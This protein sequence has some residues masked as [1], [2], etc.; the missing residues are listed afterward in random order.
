MGLVMNIQRFSLHDGPG[1]RTTAF[2][3]GC[4]LRCRWCHNPESWLMKRRMMFYPNK[5]IGCGRCLSLCARGAH[6]F[7][8][9][10]HGMDPS[11]CIG[12]GGL[13]ACVQ[14]SPAEAMTVCGK[15]YTPEELVRQL[16]K[17]R[18]FYEEDGGVTF[19]GGE[20]LGQDTFLRECLRLCKAQGLHT[21]VDTAACVDSEKLL[22]V[23][24]YTDLFL[25]DLKAMDPA[26]HEKLCGVEN[27]RTIENIRLLG[28]MGKPMWIRIPLVRGE[29]ATE[30]E[31][32]AMAQ[33]LRGVPT[34]ER[35]DVFP[36][37]NHAQD[38]YR[39]L[40]IQGELFNEEGDNQELIE[41]SIRILEK[42]SDGVLNLNRLM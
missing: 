21:C 6:V 26:L 4:N 41:T 40:G 30:S 39:A 19:S 1:V 28:E 3:M 18:I 34:V 35:V 27:S 11:R 42:E 9:S 8:E 31:L 5:C 23:A 37:L 7:S 13:D 17:D 33:F 14:A 20:V 10:G 2:L 36:V 25:V 24:E 15:E 22:R 32:R 12:C 29:N 38:K 16:A